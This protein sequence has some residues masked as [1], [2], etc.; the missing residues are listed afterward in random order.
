MQQHENLN[1]Y[2]KIDLI[3]F[4]FYTLHYMPPKKLQMKVISLF[5]YSL[6]VL[7]IGNKK[8]IKI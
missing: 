2:D 1:L 8:P 7:I 4:S 6:F 3:F 5:L